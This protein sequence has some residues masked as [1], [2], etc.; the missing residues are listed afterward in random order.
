MSEFNYSIIIPYRDKYNMLLTA[1]ESIPDRQDIQVIIIDNSEKPLFDDRVPK[2]ENAQVVF[3]TSPPQAGAGCARNVGLKE[4]KGQFLLFLDS[5]DYF[6]KEAFSA[7]DD[8][9]GSDYDIIFFKPTSISLC[10]GRPAK[11]HT[12]YSKMIEELKKTKDDNQLR[13]CWGAPW[14]KLIRAEMVKSNEIL[15][16]EV[17]V[18]NDV[19]FS[20]MTGHA[21]KTI[22]V[23]ESVVYTITAGESGSS[24]TRTCT[25]E[26]WF[27]RYQEMIRVNQ[28]LKSVGKYKYR[29]RL[30]GALRIAWR[31]F[32][33]KE[34]L[35]FLKYA[36]DNKIGVF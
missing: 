20:V 9:L 30:K 22:A 7:F 36:Y 32:G 3:L 8:Y 28:F 10:D 26:N 21:A 29:I 31:D 13:Y 2:K 34:L 27:I 12:L 5:D 35:R 15:F 11:R 25:K 23:N 4:A 17:R 18:S 6:T 33:F 24:L 14:S 16:H 19:W 1:V